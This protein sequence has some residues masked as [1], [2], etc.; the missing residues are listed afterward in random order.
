MTEAF[1]KWMDSHEGTDWHWYIK[2][3]AANDTLATKAHQAGPYLPNNFAFLLF[4]SLKKSRIDNPK[5]FFRGSVDSHGVPERELVATWYR[6]AKNECRITRWGGASSPVLDPESTGGITVFAFRKVDTSDADYVAAW[7]CNSLEEDLLT[8][9]V[10][11]IE[12]GV[13]LLISR[14]TPEQKILPEPQSCALTAKTLP[15]PWATCFP[16]GEEIIIKCIEL[17]RL[18]HKTPDDRLIDRR[19]CEFEMFRSI[20]NLHVLPRI[21]QGFVTVDEFVEYSNSVNNRRKSRSGRSLEL[22]LKEILREENV[23]FG[24]G[25]TSEG[26]KRP[27]FLFPSAEAYRRNIQPLWMLAAKTTVKDRWR[28]ILNEANLIPKKHL[29]T[30]Q[31]GVSINQFQEMRDSDVSLVVPK[32][33]QGRYPKYVRPHLMS[34]MEFISLVKRS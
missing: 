28:Q 5:S 27:D 11:P 13:P 32:P 2:R 4:P 7:V 21:K 30:L 18:T 17:R 31:E 1:Q 26:N 14:L 24:H 33:L 19:A 9:R 20:E 16:T 12:P 25:E 10:G 22:H 34:L 6:A 15:P 29:I 23:S 8:E 3:L